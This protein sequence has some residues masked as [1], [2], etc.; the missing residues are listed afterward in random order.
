MRH[1]IDYYRARAAECE[2]QAEQIKD[3]RTRRQ[4]QLLAEHWRL[5]AEQ[6]EKHGL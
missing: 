4:Y 2:R 5:L 6:F 1:L 3:E